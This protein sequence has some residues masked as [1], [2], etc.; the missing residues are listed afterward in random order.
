MG[1]KQKHQPQKKTPYNVLQIKP[2][3]IETPKDDIVLSTKA[4]ET[5][6]FEKRLKI[7]DFSQHP[8]PTIK[9][10][11]T[12]QLQQQYSM[13]E[14]NRMSDSELIDTLGNIRWHQI[15]DLFQFSEDTKVF[16]SK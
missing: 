14:L 9:L 16:L 12:K 1:Y 6:S 15:T 8:A 10:A 5:L 7:G 3:G 2:A 4:D 11:E 13:A